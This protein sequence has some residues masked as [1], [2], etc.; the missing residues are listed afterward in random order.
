LPDSAKADLEASCTNGGINVSALE[1]L[2]ITDKSR[3]HIEG[4]LNG[5]G[6]SIVLETTNGGIRVRPRS[7]NAAPTDT[8]D[9]KE[10]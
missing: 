9:D 2:A 4:K 5:G 1:K 3:R 7:G 10:R 8:D 6:T